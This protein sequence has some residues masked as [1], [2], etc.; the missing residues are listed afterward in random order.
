MNCSL[1]Y[2]W[3]FLLEIIFKSIEI[4]KK[5][6]RR[7]ER[8]IWIKHLTFYS[9]AF[10]TSW[11]QTKGNWSKVFFNQSEMNKWNELHIRSMTF[12]EK[13]K[14]KLGLEKRSNSVLGIFWFSR[15]VETEPVE[16][17]ESDGFDDLGDTDETI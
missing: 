17:D 7:L 2:Q 6:D 10:Y 3:N 16:S 8:K 13:N 4:N 5:L 15:K 1:I 14:R 11:W 12:D 9:L